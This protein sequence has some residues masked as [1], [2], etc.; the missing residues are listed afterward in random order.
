MI[1]STSFKQLNELKAENNE[2][3]KLIDYLLKNNL[4]A[5]KDPKDGEP[6]N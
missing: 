6:E 1:C 2:L 4:S 3:A 5:D